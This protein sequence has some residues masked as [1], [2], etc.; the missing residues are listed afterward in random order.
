MW[1]YLTFRF[2]IQHPITSEIS[3]GDR[4]GLSDNAQKFDFAH[5]PE[6]LHSYYYVKRFSKQPS[7]QQN[8]VHCME[9]LKESQLR[10]RLPR[11]LDK[12]ADNPF[13]IGGMKEERKRSRYFDEFFGRRRA[14]WTSVSVFGRTKRGRS[15]I[16]RDIAIPNRDFFVSS[17][18]YRC[19]SS[20]GDGTEAFETVDCIRGFISLFSETRDIH[21]RS[22]P[23]F[24]FVY[25]GN[26]VRLGPDFLRVATYKVTFR[27]ARMLSM[28]PSPSTP[29]T[30]DIRPLWRIASAEPVLRDLRTTRQEFRDNVDKARSGNAVCLIKYRADSEGDTANTFYS[31]C[32]WICYKLV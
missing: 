31:L 13:S 18:S 32:I 3:T 23:L 20:S 7:S 12:L 6:N 16:D 9:R 14:G 27:I 21:G 17:V 11:R 22:I 24:V 30:G 28:R 15:P 10:C 4:G 25:R 26:C 29:T 8:V 1:L 5:R 19:P 2:T